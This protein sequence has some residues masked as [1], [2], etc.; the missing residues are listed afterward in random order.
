MCQA[1]IYTLEGAPKKKLSWM[2][3]GKHGKGKI[4]RHYVWPRIYCVLSAE[5]MK[6]GSNSGFMPLQQQPS[7]VSLTGCS[8]MAL[9]GCCSFMLE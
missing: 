3:T 4:V 8:P 1:Y 2:L 6:R 7:W 5:G 9:Q